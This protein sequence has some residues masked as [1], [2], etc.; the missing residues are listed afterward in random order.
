[1]RKKMCLSYLFN[2]YKIIFTVIILALNVI[3]VLSEIESDEDIKYIT[4]MKLPCME[5][6]FQRKLNSPHIRRIL[7]RI[8]INSN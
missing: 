3:N 8:D 2:S 6:K 7:I 4:V 5:S 1:M